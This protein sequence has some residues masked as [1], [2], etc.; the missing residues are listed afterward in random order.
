MKNGLNKVYNRGISKITGMEL[1]GSRQEANLQ[2]LRC[3]YVDLDTYRG[4][5][6]INWR[7]ATALV[8][9]MADKGLIPHPTVFA[10]SGRGAYALWAIKPH[11]S[12][13]RDILTY[14]AINRALGKAFKSFSH[15]LQPDDVFDAARVLRLPGS[16]NSKAPENP[17]AYVMQ[18]DREGGS[19]Q[20]TLEEVAER[21]SVPLLPAPAR[22]DLPTSAPPSIAP[23]EPTPV[24]AVRK[25]KDEARSK[26]GREGMRA[27]GRRRLQELQEIIRFKAVTKG[28][29]YRTLLILAS[30]ARA[31]GMPPSE[32]TSLLSD[33][34]TA[35]NPPYPGHDANDVPVAEIVAGAYSASLVTR[36]SATGL[37]KFF[38]LSSDDCRH[39][40]L[41]SI[42]TPEI[43]E[44]RRP[45]TSR[46]SKLAIRRAIEEHGPKS[47]TLL[48]LK[49]RLLAA[50]GFSLSRSQLC[51]LVK[52]AGVKIGSRR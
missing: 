13:A 34:A 3:L 5:V 24:I 16:V 19:Y 14:K 43:E 35:F 10:N 42:Y 32:A 2:D 37:A 9:K 6:P 50:R 38:N 41:R 47:A 15:L 7:D 27:L 8:Q 40:M 25:V 1:R 11:E 21:M 4:H 36:H 20:Y 49:N 29:R 48:E 23:S 18:F 39:L 51:R 28:F 31:A 30:T 26:A 12:K 45:K 52:R 22:T 33:I 46:V 17:V 44:L